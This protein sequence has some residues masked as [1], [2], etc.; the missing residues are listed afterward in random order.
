LKVITVVHD[1]DDDGNIYRPLVV[2]VEQSVVCVSV[3][4]T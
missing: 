1:D 2:W 4:L 3:C